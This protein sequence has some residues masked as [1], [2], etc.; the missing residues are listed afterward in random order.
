MHLPLVVIVTLQPAAEPP[1]MRAARAAGAVVALVRIEPG[2]DGISEQETVWGVEVRAPNVGYGLAADLGVAAATGCGVQRP[3]ILV[4]NDDVSFPTGGAALQELVTHPRLSPA[5]VALSLQPRG[6][7]RPPRVAYPGVRTHLRD[8]LLPAHIARRAGAAG[9]HAPGFAVLVRWEAFV[10]V[11][12]FDPRFFLYYEEVDL[13]RRLEAAGGKVIEV[14]APLVHVGGGSTERAYEIGLR[15][16]LGRSHGELVRT[17]MVRGSVLTV[18]RLLVL[19]R[20]SA[21]ALLR[22]E[23]RRVV[24]AFA[25]ARGL[26]EG[27]TGQAEA[28]THPPL[29]ALARPERQRVHAAAFPRGGSVGR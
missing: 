7:A 21:T 22:G 4:L 17:S 5:V 9:V 11:G 27:L 1:A 3:W 18:L 24:H 19:V 8:L 16:E 28:L 15:R 14:T 2:R 25:E 23:P 12:G 29:L 10:D 13:Y 20:R 26:I 6:V